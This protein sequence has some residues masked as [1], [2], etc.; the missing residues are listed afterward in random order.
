MTDTNCMGVWNILMSFFLFVCLLSILYACWPTAR[1]E[2][3]EIERE[4]GS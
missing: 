1:E 2:L 3:V 4:E